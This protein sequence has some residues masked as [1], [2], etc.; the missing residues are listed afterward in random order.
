VDTEQPTR[1]TRP[2]PH[3]ALLVRGGAAEQADE[4]RE[5]AEEQV[6]P[7]G[8]LDNLDQI[9]GGDRVHPPTLD[10]RVDEGMQTDRAQRA[11][12]TGGDVPVEMRDHALGEAVGLDLVLQGHGAQGRN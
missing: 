1:I 6:L 10:P 12:A 5:A 4:D 3:V 7:A 2:G 9:L 8:E 11:R